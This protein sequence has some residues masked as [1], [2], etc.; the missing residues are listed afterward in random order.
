MHRI[1]YLNGFMASGKSTIGPILANTLG[2]DF[3]DL[4]KVIEKEEG[5][6]I[7]QIFEDKGEKYFR[8]KETEILKK[9]SESDKK[10]ISLG[11]G[12]S[13]FNNN[14]EFIRNTGKVIYLKT[15]PE[16]LF[17]RLRFKNDRPVFNR[18]KNGNNK[19]NLKLKISELLAQRTPYYEQADYIINTDEYPLG[20]IIDLIA[21]FIHKSV[22][23]K[24]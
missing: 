6:S 5:K 9:V 7:V 24:N 10:I 20:Q 8:E 11:G 1:I 15:S 12:T 21:K 4:D 17:N 13:V 19:E 3:Y 14:L 16:S 22:H 18:E 23:E 2:W